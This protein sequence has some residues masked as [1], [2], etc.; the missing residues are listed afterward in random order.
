M[1]IALITGSAGLIGS[2]SACFFHEK[3]LQII[4][5]DND[6]RKFFFGEEASTEWNRESLK[7]E[8]PDYIHYNTDIRDEKTIFNIFKEYG[9]GNSLVTAI[10]NIGFKIDSGEFVSMQCRCARS[11]IEVDV[12]I[13]GVNVASPFGMYGI[14]IPARI[15]ECITDIANPRT[16]APHS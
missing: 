16:Q 2:E 10:A 13:F 6:M 8:I 5:I 11:I 15:D 4:G 7:K 14:S 9:S 12:H 3:G 1:D